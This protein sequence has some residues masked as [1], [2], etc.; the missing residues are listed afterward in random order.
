MIKSQEEK[1]SRLKLAQYN[2]HNVFYF[3]VEVCA[4]KS[5]HMQDDVQQTLQSSSHGQFVL[6]C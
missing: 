6:F 5:F 1:L 2:L 4:Q 3:Q